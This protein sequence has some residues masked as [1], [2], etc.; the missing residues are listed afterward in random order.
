[1]NPLWK[2]VKNHP[3]ELL[4]AA[5]IL[6][7]FLIKLHDVNIP[8]YWDEMGVYVPAAFHMKDAGHISL[9]PGSLDPL[10]SRGHPMLFTFCNALVFKIFG[11]TI[12]VGHLF[13]LFLGIATLVLFFIIAK[14]SLTRKLP[15]LP[16]SFF[17]SSQSFLPYR[18]RS[19]R[20]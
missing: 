16:R 10:F 20:R 19:F 8:Y 15:S 11:E 13:A 9:L 7:F 4:T 14:N 2:L 5:V 3:Y 1:M 17:R 18:Y 12:T 6:V